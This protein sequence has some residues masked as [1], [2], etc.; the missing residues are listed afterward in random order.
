MAELE[1]LDLLLVQE[2]T[3]ATTTQ[4]NVV[5]N[6]YA[7]ESIPLLNFLDASGKA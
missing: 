6:G 1:P 5:P 2:K 7:Y 4:E 3:S